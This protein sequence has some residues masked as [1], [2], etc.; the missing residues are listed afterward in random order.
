M[1]VLAQSPET[2]DFIDVKVHEDVALS[3]LRPVICLMF[4]CCSSHVAH[5]ML[6]TK[7]TSKVHGPRSPE[8]TLNF[9]DGPVPQELLALPSAAAAAEDTTPSTAPAPPQTPTPTPL[10]QSPSPL[11]LT[12]SPVEPPVPKQLPTP[13]PPPPPTAWLHPNRTPRLVLP[14][15]ASAK[16]PA[17][18]ANQNQE[19]SWLYLKQKYIAWM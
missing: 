14:P 1:V 17:E 11:P 16:A 12:L 19:D 4:V 8:V 3:G 15:K 2:K 5:H 10:P 6:S 18:P 9:G 7:S 13:P